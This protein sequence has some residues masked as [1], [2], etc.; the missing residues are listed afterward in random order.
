M[1]L[2]A[3]AN[4]DLHSQTDPKEERAAVARAAELLAG[5]LQRCSREKRR[6]SR[7][8]RLPRR[9][10]SAAQG[11]PTEDRR[12][13]RK[14]PAGGEGGIFLG[15]RRKYFFRVFRVLKAFR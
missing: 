3:T 14:R 2:L 10:W 15:F 5:L 7:D 9:S 11:Q 6:G 12:P 8:G 1:L 4:I 13:E